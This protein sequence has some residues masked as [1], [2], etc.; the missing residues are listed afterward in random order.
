LELNKDEQG[1]VKSW[2]VTG[3]DVFDA[4]QRMVE[5]DY[6][7]TCCYDN[8]N[9]CIAVFSNPRGDDHRHSGLTL[10]ARGSSVFKAMKQLVWKHFEALR[11]DWT[12]HIPQY[13][14]FD[15]DD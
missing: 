10:T 1:T 15:I 3:D 13:G 2:D 11:E 4:I 8:K 12:T 9:K 6:S 5:G 14:G 7:I